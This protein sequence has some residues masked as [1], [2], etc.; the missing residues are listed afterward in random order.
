LR[1]YV[2][3]LHDQIVY[4]KGKIKSSRS[5]LVGYAEYMYEGFREKLEKYNEKEKNNG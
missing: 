1:K 5:H 2:D 3:Y 4:W